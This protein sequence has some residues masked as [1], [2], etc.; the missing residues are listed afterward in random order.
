MID[1]NP[2]EKIKQSTN[3]VQKAVELAQ[4]FGST[5]LVKAIQELQADNLALIAENMSLKEQLKKK[6]K[7]NMQFSPE[8]NCYWD[9]KD[10]GKKDGPFCS[11]CYETKGLSVR[12]L[13]KNG[14]YYC[15]NCKTNIQTSEYIESETIMVI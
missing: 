1:Q 13:G 7:H 9:L 11:N 3:I 8:D 12:F 5:D 14:L 2:I 6:Q 15:P 10:D 4:A